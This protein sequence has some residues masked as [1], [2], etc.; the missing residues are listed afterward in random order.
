MVPTVVSGT[1]LVRGHMGL[2]RTARDASGER[3]SGEVQSPPASANRVPRAGQRARAGSGPVPPDLMWDNLF[4]A[5]KATRAGL[6][7]GS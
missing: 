4:A 1:A 2:L 7:R 3:E 6:R 5:M